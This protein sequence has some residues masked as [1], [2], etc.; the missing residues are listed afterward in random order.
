MKPDEALICDIRKLKRIA[1]KVE[2]IRSGGDAGRWKLVPVNL[3]RKKR[4][5]V[6]RTPRGF[7]L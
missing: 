6:R 2:E 1:R 5:P 4:G 7:F 3:K